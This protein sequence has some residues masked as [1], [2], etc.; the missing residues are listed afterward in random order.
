M[1]I[2]GAT[3][4]L[5]R[6]M[7]A[8][9]ADAGYRVAVHTRSRRD[10]AERLRQ[11]L[12]DPGAHAVVEADLADA[13]AVVDAFEALAEQWGSPQDLVNA[14]WPAVPAERHDA[15]TEEAL[16]AGLLGVRCHAHLVRAAL[17]GIRRARGSVVF[18]GG[19][20]STRLHPGLGL[21]AA[22]KAAATALTH[23]LAL[24]EGPAGVRANVISPGRVA[25]AANDLADEIDEFRDL[26]RI[27]E[28]RRVLPMPTP[29][30]IARTALW[31]LSPAASAITGQTVSLAGGER[32]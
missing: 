27:G 29:G 23:V 31:L 32:V 3:G 7:V 6:S 24:E 5:G 15:M 12:K 22:G 11:S 26:D 2:A 28:L 14:A 18:L 20:L 19:A 9:F 17:P 8:V 25:V 4:E 16:A 30:D 21:F 13:E 10:V 1:F